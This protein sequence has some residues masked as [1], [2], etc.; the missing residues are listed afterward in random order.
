MNENF[1]SLF[2][3]SAL[4]FLMSMLI[5]FIIVSFFILNSPLANPIYRLLADIT[6]KQKKYAFSLKCYKKLFDLNEFLGNSSQY[7]N[8]TALCHEHLGNFEQAINWYKKTENWAKVG[9]LNLDIGHLE[10]AIPYFSKL[11]NYNRLAHCYEL[12]EDYHQVG[13]IYLEQLNNKRKAFQYFEKAL[14]ET[15]DIPT[16]LQ[17]AAFIHL[18]FEHHFSEKGNLYLTRLTN[19]IKANPG[20]KFPEQLKDKIRNIQALSKNNISDS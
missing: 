9:Q 6:F 20:A 5:I 19:F 1:V 18:C 16:T 8:K 3:T 14:P 4:L 13:L 11:K 12:L 15:M 7:A 10:E 2:N 17:Y